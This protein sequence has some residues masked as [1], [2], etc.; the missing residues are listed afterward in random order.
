MTGYGVGPRCRRRAGPCDG[1]L[2]A[3]GFGVDAL[4]DGSARTCCMEK[5]KSYLA[6]SPGALALAWLAGGAVYMRRAVRSRSA[7]IRAAPA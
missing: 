1:R 5:G 4:A 2:A 6:R 3:A 7:A